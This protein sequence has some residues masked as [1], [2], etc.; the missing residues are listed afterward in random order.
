MNLN[1]LKCCLNPKVIAGV[2]AVGFGV[3]V[4]APGVFTAALPLLVLAICPLSMVLMMGMMTGGGSKEAG[5]DTAGSS[6]SGQPEEV[7]GSPVASLQ[8]RVAELERELGRD[9]AGRPEVAGSTAPP[10]AGW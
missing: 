8:A 1:A 2:V 6:S 9:A 10:H 5:S 3:Y 7:D 4:F